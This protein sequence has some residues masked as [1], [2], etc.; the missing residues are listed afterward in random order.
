[1][2]VVETPT[3]EA[4]YHYCFTKKLGYKEEY[5]KKT[6]KLYTTKKN[7]WKSRIPIMTWVNIETTYLIYYSRK[8]KQKKSKFWLL[9]TFI[10]RRRAAIVRSFC[11]CF[12]A[13]RMN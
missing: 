6:L 9:A 4:D 3:D 11:F 2:R 12:F 5:S 1:M 7:T 10:K 8:E 13:S